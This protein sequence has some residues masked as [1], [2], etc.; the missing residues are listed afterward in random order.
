MPTLLTNLRYTNTENTTIEMVVQIDGHPVLNT[1]HPFH[2]VPWDSEP[3][4]QA[5]KAALASGTYTIAPYV[6]P[7]LLPTHE[8]PQTGQSSV[9]AD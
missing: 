5:V 8:Q 6:P 7:A 9:I 4:A 2:Y 3:V 1:P